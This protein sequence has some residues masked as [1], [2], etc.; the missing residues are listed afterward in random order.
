MRMSGGIS[1]LC[2]VL[3]LI[4][5]FVVLS[6]PA[7]ADDQSQKADGSSI[8][9]EGL[10]VG[11]RDT[12]AIGLFKKLSLK[13]DLDRLIVNFQAFHGGAEEANIEKLESSFEKLVNNTLSLLHAK[14]PDLHQRVSAARSQLWFR[15]RDPDTFQ[16]MVVVEEPA[17][18]SM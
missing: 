7:L 9:L 3:A 11:L 10:E 14:D 8:N 16:A 18:Q 13:R 12:N 1:L 4:A 2:G 6:E 5:F 17:Y 15:L